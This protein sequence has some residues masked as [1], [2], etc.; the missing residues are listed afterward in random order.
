MWEQM[1]P[2]RDRDSCP[3]SGF[4]LRS[5]S[6]RRQG[7]LAPAAGSSVPSIQTLG[8]F[9]G[10]RGVRDSGGEGCQEG[11]RMSVNRCR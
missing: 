11:G 6:H 9:G 3:G 1:L 5:R 2:S 4:D 8:G 10:G 7:M